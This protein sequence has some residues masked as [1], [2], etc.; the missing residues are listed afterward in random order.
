MEAL[1]ERFCGFP[2][3]APFFHFAFGWAVSFLLQITG[4]QSFF[5][6]ITCCLLGPALHLIWFQP[7]NLLVYVFET[8]VMVA[9]PAVMSFF[10]VMGFMFRKSPQKGGYRTDYLLF[11]IPTLSHVY[12]LHHALVGGGAWAPI[13]LRALV[14]FVGLMAVFFNAKA[15]KIFGDKQKEE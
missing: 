4:S 10:I 9:A 5:A 8:S 12:F 2:V 11:S 7:V 1:G 6:V 14:V 13:E 3:F 15:C